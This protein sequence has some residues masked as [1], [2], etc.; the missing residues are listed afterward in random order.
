MC[1]RTLK[2]GV[3]RRSSTGTTGTPGD[4]RRMKPREKVIIPEPLVIPPSGNKCTQLCGAAAGSGV[5][6][7]PLR[8][9]LPL[10]LVLHMLSLPSVLL[11]LLPLRLARM[12]AASSV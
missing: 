12:L 9:S 4:T 5:L 1:V 3:D 2:P 11:R 8:L 6:L 7:L 10:L